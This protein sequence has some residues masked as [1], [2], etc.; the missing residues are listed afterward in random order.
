M[1]RVVIPGVQ[2]GLHDLRVLANVLLT[3]SGSSNFLQSIVHIGRSLHIPRLIVL[4]VVNE[5]VV[6]LLCSMFFVRSQ[7]FVTAMCRPGRLLKIR[8]PT[9]HDKSIS[10]EHISRNLESREKLTIACVRHSG[11]SFFSESRAV[12]SIPG[13]LSKSMIRSL[14]RGLHT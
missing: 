3:M 12:L 10:L 13:S 7:E 14:N 9:A 5:L 1:Y 6:S 8:K 11:G 2:N 4:E